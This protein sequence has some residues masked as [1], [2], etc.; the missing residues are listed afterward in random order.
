VQNL[1][2]GNNEIIF[3]QAGYLHTFDPSNNSAAKLTVGIATDLLELRPRF[4]KGDNYIRS[5]SVSPT[6]ARVVMNFR[7]EIVTVP[8]KK[9]CGEYNLHPGVH[10]KNPV[11]SP[12]GKFI[13]YFSDE[14]GEYALHVHDQSELK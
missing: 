10:E 12:N 11:W 1:S 4:V 3:E 14:S 9:G 8:G 13:A 7:G 2:A 5:A 6:G